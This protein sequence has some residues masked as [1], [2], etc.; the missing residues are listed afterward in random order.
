M[1]L[2]VPN[3]EDLFGFPVGDLHLKIYKV[4]LENSKNNQAILECMSESLQKF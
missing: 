1:S 2:A 3:K 4:I